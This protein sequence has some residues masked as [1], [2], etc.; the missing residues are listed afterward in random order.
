MCC[1]CNREGFF[2]IELRWLE[3]MTKWR[4][5]FVFHMCFLICFHRVCIAIETAAVLCLCMCVF[6]VTMFVWRSTAWVSDLWVSLMCNVFRLCDQTFVITL[7]RYGNKDL[8]RFF[9]QRLMHWF[10][11]RAGWEW[12]WFSSISGTVWD[13]VIIMAIARKVRFF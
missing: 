10:N 4:T 8:G 3:E 12:K 1:V 7:V 2:L 13:N 11:F 5:A 9:T 6:T